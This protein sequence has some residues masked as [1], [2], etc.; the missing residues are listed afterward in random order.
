MLPITYTIKGIRNALSDL[1]AGDK[2]KEFE[3]LSKI[4]TSGNVCQIL[5]SVLESPEQLQELA[6]RS[7][8]H[9]NGFSKLILSSSKTHSL[10][11]HIYWND[12]AENY[13]EN[14]HNHR[15][16]FSSF[17]LKGAL[18]Q[19]FFEIIDHPSVETS[20]HVEELR[21]YIYKPLQTHNTAGAMRY[22]TACVGKSWVKKKGELTVPEGCGY[23]LH[24]DQLH[25]VRYSVDSGIGVTL[26]LYTAPYKPTCDLYSMS[27]QFSDTTNQKHKT[28]DYTTE[29]FQKAL[30]FARDLLSQAPSL[31]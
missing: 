26:I 15:W 20:A 12:S 4:S 24:R 6:G 7:Y 5:T 9:E 11:L 2:T 27:E 18:T 3:L 13:Q 31:V 14:I 17:V 16:D 30:T 29:A 23:H 8:R 10:R 1:P 19:D 28:K 25:R 21:H 22:Q